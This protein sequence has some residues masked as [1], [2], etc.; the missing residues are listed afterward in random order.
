MKIIVDTIPRI[1]YSYPD[2][3]IKRE[4]VNMTEAQG[5]SLLIGVALLWILFAT[6]IAFWNTPKGGGK[7]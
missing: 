6:I 7:K 2:G 5:F 3:T 4:G 1:D